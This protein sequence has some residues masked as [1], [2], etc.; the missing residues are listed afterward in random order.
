MAFAKTTTLF[1]TR[2][3]P[4]QCGLFRFCMKGLAMKT[5]ITI[6]TCCF[7]VAAAQASIAI[8]FA[9]CILCL[10][11]GAMF[12]PAQTFGFIGI[13]ILVTLFSRYPGWC[14]AGTAIVC[15]AAWSGGQE[16]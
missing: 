6:L 11:W 10:V 2:K 9:I 12:R 15:M 3:G 8:I 1:E 4:P 13:C 5:A 16:I 14:L 7:I